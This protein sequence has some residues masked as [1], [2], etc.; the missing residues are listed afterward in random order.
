MR[1]PPTSGKHGPRFTG[2]SSGQ[3]ALLMG[4]F[5]GIAVLLTLDGPGLTIDEP[6]DVR[7]G[8]TYVETLRKQ[9]WHFLDREVVDRVFRD[10]AEHPPLGRWLLGIASEVGEPIEVLWK[11]PDP[12]GHYVLAGRMAPALAFAALVW[13]VT[14]TAG[15]RW[16][17]AA[18]VAAGFA[19]VAMPRV[20]AHAHLGALDTFLSLFWTLALVAGDRALRARRPSV[21]MAGAGALWGLA[22]LTKIHAW[23]LLPILCTWSFVRLPPRRAGLAMLSWTIAGISVFWLGWPWLWYDSWNR[24][25]AYLGTGVV[26][27]TIMVQY[28]GQVVADRDVPWHYPWFYFIATVPIGL[29]ALG[30]VGLGCGWHHRRDD[31]F[32]L[33][34][35]ATIAVFLGI[36]STRVPVY[37]G[38][39]LFLHV[40]PASA[41][42]I[43]LGFGWLWEQR[44]KGARGR[45]A[46]VVLLLVQAHGVI[47]LHPFGLS[48]YNGLV[49]GLPGAVRLGLELTYWN[50]AVDHVLLDRLAHDANPGASAALVPTL[51]PGQGIL[52]TNRA[53]A[54]RDIILSDE[55]EG[56][57]AEWLVVSRRTAYWRPEIKER[58]LRGEGQLVT[59]SSRQ[60]VWIAA[61]WHFP[62]VNSTQFRHN[63]RQLASP[64]PRSATENA[65]SKPFLSRDLRKLAPSH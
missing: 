47:A 40:F 27:S 42:L 20:F 9:G 5:A 45:A 52:T 41:M 63:P 35:A 38:E 56:T 28:F 17:G 21:A 2:L 50:D 51:Y 1:S 57:R 14:H 12:T 29:L 32:P 39:R 34:L 61:L 49:G 22:L 6:L 64:S 62:R 60:G 54:R 24:F 15:R 43:G 8:R 36:F 48:Y 11:G 3:L 65:V 4:F 53:L 44:L 10:N 23:F 18:G 16:G 37:D 19:L 30:A 58:L 13:L 7:P 33:L 25:Q 55:Q 46:R 59:A 31:P 26:R